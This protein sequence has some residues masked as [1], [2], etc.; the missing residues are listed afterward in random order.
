ML[1]AVYSRDTLE[2]LIA[3][4]NHPRVLGLACGIVPLGLSAT[5]S[6]TG[7]NVWIARAGLGDTYTATPAKNIYSLWPCPLL[8]IS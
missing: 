6:H 1:F 4:Q 2:A 5:R 3:P 7:R 8:F